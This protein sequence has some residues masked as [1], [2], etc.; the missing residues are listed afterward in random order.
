LMVCHPFLSIHGYSFLFVSWLMW[1][2]INTL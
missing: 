1:M 2:F